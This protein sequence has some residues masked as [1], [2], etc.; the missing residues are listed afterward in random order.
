MGILDKTKHIITCQACDISETV[1]V[2]QTGTESD[3]A[4]AAW[5]DS[6]PAKDFDLKWE[7]GGR[8]EP[9]IGSAKCLK[10]GVAASIA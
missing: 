8:Q 2:R 9:K 7:G 1:E 5:D 3:Y 4:N 6:A 10:C